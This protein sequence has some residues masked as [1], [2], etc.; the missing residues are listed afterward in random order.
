M[1]TQNAYALQDRCLKCLGSPVCASAGVRIL[2]AQR[3]TATAHCSSPND[4]CHLSDCCGIHSLD[5]SSH[6]NQSEAVNVA[7]AVKQ[8]YQKWGAL[9]PRPRN[10]CRP[11]N[12]FIKKQ[13]THRLKP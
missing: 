10:C 9:P 13:Y 1:L 12:C 5:E 4:N 7:R 6:L 11:L 3:N 2:S 8:K